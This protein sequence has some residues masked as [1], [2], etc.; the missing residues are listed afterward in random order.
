MIILQTNNPYLLLVYSDGTSFFFGIKNTFVYFTH[1]SHPCYD[2][3]IK[4]LL[5][6]TIFVEQTT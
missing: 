3:I 1:L 5:L 4:K 6:S 2:N